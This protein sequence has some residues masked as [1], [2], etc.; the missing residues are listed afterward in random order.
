MRVFKTFGDIRKLFAERGFGMRS[1]TYKCPGC[2]VSIWGWKTEQE[3]TARSLGRD[4]GRTGTVFE[5]THPACGK[6]W[7]RIRYPAT[8][9]TDDDPWRKSGGGGGR[10]SGGGGQK[11]WS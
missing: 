9:W 7:D 6:V 11:K 8:E 3:N 10:K 1:L 4:R 5:I 2:G